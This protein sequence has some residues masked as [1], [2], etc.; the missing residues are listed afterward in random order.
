[1][2]RLKQVVNERVCIS[3]LM[4]NILF[5]SHIKDRAVRK[6]RK[7]LESRDVNEDLARVLRVMEYNITDLPE[8]APPPVNKDKRP[9][10][11][12]VHKKRKL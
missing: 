3:Y 10:F 8:I 1:M 7:L 9:I 5:F 6:A 11:K 4:T 12:L 2:D